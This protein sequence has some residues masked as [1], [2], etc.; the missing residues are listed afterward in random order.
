MF[1]PDSASIYSIV[2]VLAVVVETIDGSL[3]SP[4][5]GPRH[6]DQRSETQITHYQVS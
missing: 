3:S 1:V 2:C 4:N 6:A 5:D